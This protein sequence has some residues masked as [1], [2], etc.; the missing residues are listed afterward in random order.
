MALNDELM[1]SLRENLTNFRE[2][3]VELLTTDRGLN[4]DSKSVES[5][6]TF[7]NESSN[8]GIITGVN[9]IYYVIHGRGPGRFPPPD[10]HGNW[11]LPFPAAEKIAKHG[12]KEKY[13]PIADKFDRLFSDL[14]N[15]IRKDSNNISLAYIKKIGTI[16]NVNVK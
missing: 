14:F 9:Y 12:N 13:K 5:L 8:Y 2:D 1:N 3:L 6:I 7:I 16:R 4:L 15:T 10:E 11:P